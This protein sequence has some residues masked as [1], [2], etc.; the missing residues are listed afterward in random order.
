MKKDLDEKNERFGLS[1][2]R[3]HEIVKKILPKA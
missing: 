3:F 2:R 1:V